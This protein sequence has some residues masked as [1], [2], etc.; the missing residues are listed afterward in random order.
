MEPHTWRLLAEPKRVSFTGPVQ[1]EFIFSPARRSSVDEFLA[2][3][4]RRIPMALIRNPRARRY[5]LRLR[6]DGSARVT[7]PRGGSVAEA[8]RFAER[9]R[10]W[11]ER[12][13]QRMP[14]RATGP[15]GLFIGTQI[16]F[17]GEL[18]TI[19]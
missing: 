3:N 4:G 19:E 12:A 2:V 17:R 18:V 5:V 1:F 10:A 8:K 13:L 16:H 7:I 14:P 15:R 11:L 9:N 6:P